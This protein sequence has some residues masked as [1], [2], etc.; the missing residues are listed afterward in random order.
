MWPSHFPG[1]P[2]FFPLINLLCYN[3]LPMKRKTIAICESGYHTESNVKIIAGLI[4]KAKEKNVNLL[5]FNSQMIKGDFP[6]GIDNNSN[7][8]KGES[9]IFNLINYQKIDGLIVFGNSIYREDTIL[10]IIKLCEKNNVPCININDPSHQLAHNVIISN[11][12]SMEL[13][14][15]HLVKDHKLTKINFIGGFRDNKETTERLDAYKRVLTKYKIPIEEDRI[16]YGHFWTHSVDCVK[17]FLRK[18]VPQAIVCANDTMAIFVCDYLK[19]EGYKI[20]KDIIVTGFDGISDAFTYEPSITTVRHRFEYAGEVAFEMMQKLLSG[21]SRV[22]DE[23]ITSE[24]IIQESCGCHPKNKKYHNYIANKYERRDAYIEFT[25]HM[26]RTDI[27]FSDEENIDELFDHISSPLTYFNLKQIQFCVDSELDSTDG[28]VFSSKSGKYGIPTKLN[29]IIPFYT[30]FSANQTFA[31][32]D[33]LDTDFL[34]ESEPAFRIFTA[35]YYK[36]RCLGYIAYEPENYLKFEASA[37]MLWVYNSAEKI[38]SFCLKRELENLNLKDHFTGLY[39]RRG[40]EKY[41]SEVYKNVI[42][43]D[44]YITVI[45]IDID[46]LKKIN[47]KFGHE[48]GDN[49]ILQTSNAIQSVFS[50]NSICV[51]TGGD[52]FCV[53]THSPKKQNIDKLIEKLTQQLEKYNSKKEVPYE[54]MCS[55]GYFTLFSKDFSS[56][57]QMQKI[58]DQKLYEVKAYHHHPDIKK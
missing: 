41:F 40:M 33:L 10:E 20:P 31:S 46:Y 16:A 17:Q 22:K 37:F 36:N 5:I 19:N 7:L 11:T 3:N 18:D 44:E 49:A 50:K 43:N 52:E 56:F 13:V 47:D 28:Y 24:L 27:Y 30:S 14:V 9:E 45:C 25:K 55:C 6:K 12:G 4:A 54:V 42:P 48:G 32:K 2:L 26:V 58:A 57:E 53:L 1:W 34:N 8:V 15:E 35:M 51:R 29:A 23:C 21:V 39:N 38:G